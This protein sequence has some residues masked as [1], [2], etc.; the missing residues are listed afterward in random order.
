MD[1]LAAGLTIAGFAITIVGNAIVTS[2]ASGKTEGIIRTEL[3][4]HKERIEKIEVEQG[5]QWKEI[6]KHTAEIGYLQGKTN[7]KARH[8]GVE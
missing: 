6:G 1:A 7:G 5:Q 4:G 2:R 3:T 8:A